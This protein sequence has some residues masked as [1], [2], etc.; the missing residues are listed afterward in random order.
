MRSW[1]L[2]A[3][4]ALAPRAH[5]TSIAGA[6]RRGQIHPIRQ[7]PRLLRR[8]RL[9]Q[10][11]PLPG[12]HALRRVDKAGNVILWLDIQPAGTVL[13]GD[14]HLL[15]CDNKHKALLDLSPDGMLSVVVDSLEGQPRTA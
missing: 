2:S 11:R 12:S 3:L 6:T 9:D 15:I 7:N 1:V 10:R 5:A 13:R 4:L 8:P 14:G